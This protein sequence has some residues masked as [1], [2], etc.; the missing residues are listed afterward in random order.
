MSLLDTF[1]TIFE[2][3]T[4]S[5]DNGLKK[6]GKGADD[7]LDKL[8][9]TDE[10]ASKTGNKFETLAKGALGWLTAAVSVG[11]TLNGVI[12]KAQEITQIAQTADALGVAVDELDAFGRVAAQLGGD[13]Q[14][15]RDSVTDMAESIGEALQ[16]VNSQRAKTFAGLKISLKDVDGQA[17]NAVEGLLRLADAVQGISRQ[18]AVFQIKQ[19]GI[20]DNR[21]VE[22][23]LKGRKELERLLKVQKEQGVVTKETAEQAKR[24]TDALNRLRGEVDSAGTKFMST[25]IPALTKVV[26][27]LTTV[28]EWAGEHSDVIVGFFAAIA[29]V[30]TAVY[31]PAMISAAVA[32]LA[33]TWPILAIAAAVVAVAAAFALAYDDVMN[34]IHGNDSLIGQI[35]EKYPKVK[36]LVDAIGAAFRLLGDVVLGIWQIIKLG[37]QQMLDFIFAGISQI[38]AGARRVLSFFGLGGE[39]SENENTGAN[40]RNGRVIMRQAAT[41]SLNSNTSNSIQNSVASSKRETNLGIQQLVVNTQATDAQ[42]VA[43]GITG[44]LGDQLSQMDVEFSSGVDR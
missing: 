2:A 23:V 1:L 34:F 12:S 13:A 18:E 4:S 31:L 38:N 26:E 21:T 44:E 30:V 10:Q 20:T 22:M 33:A 32:T 17:V 15:A 41:T 6:S 5:L 11:A 37:F 43:S 25:F 3:D 9:N 28:V 36:E 35:F 27:W 16:D 14:G 29:A 39:G 24:L 8:K 19:L 7:L 42:G 40:V